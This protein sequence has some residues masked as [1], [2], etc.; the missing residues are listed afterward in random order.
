M[1]MGLR[2]QF[3]SRY[4][5]SAVAMSDHPAPL[6]PPLQQRKERAIEA[7]TRHYASDHIDLDEFENRLDRLY[8]A[9]SV[10]EIDEVQKGLPGLDSIASGADDLPAEPPRQSQFIAAVMGGSEKKGVWRPARRINALAFM[11]GIVLDFREARFAPGTTVLT[12]VAL[13]GGI[14]IIVPPGLRVECDGI[15]IMGGFEGLSDETGSGSVSGPV[16]RIEGLALWGGVEVTQRYPAESAKEAK[17]RLKS[18]A[19]RDY[20]A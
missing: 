9:R 13:M 8:T 6:E 14:E 1:E 16:L 2:S 15:G 20:G 12:A 19:R 4:P 11:G 18:G 17:R 5:L 10:A 7:L 3:P